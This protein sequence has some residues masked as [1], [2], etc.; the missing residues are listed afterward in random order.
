MHEE[1][2]ERAG[3]W[4]VVVRGA[5]VS[6]LYCFLVWEKGMDPSDAVEVV[7]A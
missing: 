6:C 1:G 2:R 5:A 4:V 7:E 3:G